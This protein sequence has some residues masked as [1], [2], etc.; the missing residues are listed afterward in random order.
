MMSIRKVAYARSIALPDAHELGTCGVEQ[1]GNFLQTKII[2]MQLA[3][4]P[5]QSELVVMR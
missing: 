4:K 3:T 2:G 5:G 1:T